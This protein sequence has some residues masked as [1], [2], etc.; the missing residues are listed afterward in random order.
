M[1]DAL[2][3]A[4]QTIARCGASLA[5]FVELHPSLWPAVGISRADIETELHAQRLAIEPLDGVADPWSTE[6]IS[7]RVRYIG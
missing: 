6:G 7:V 4:R 1:T 5:V 2:R 3:G